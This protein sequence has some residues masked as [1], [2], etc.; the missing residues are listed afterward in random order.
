MVFEEGSVQGAFLI[1]PEPRTDERGHFARIYCEDELARRGLIAP[2]TQIN[3]GFSPCAGTL[4]GMHF[5]TAP[6]AEVKIMRCLRGAAFD[7]VVDLRPDSPTRGRWFA[8]ELSA[9]N[10]L[11]MYAPAG[12][13]HGYLTLRDDTELMYLTSKPYAPQAAQGVR[14]DDP[15]FGIE[16]PRDIT[17]VSKADRGWPDFH[18]TA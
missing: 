4:R 7:V 15:A 9:E 10:G 1:R 13:A 16:W 17:V 2:V 12:T 11:L 6:H 8:A 14:F 3:T 5:Q 18:W